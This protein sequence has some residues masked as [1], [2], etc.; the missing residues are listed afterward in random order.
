MKEGKVRSIGISNFNLAQTQD[1][2]KNCEIKPVNNQF[3]INPYIQCE[4]VV[5]FC[6]KNGIVVSGFCPVGGGQ[7]TP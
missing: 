1:V 6:Q 5:D 7:E 3:E 4:K 2:L